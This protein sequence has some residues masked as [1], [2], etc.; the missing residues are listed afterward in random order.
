MSWTWHVSPYHLSTCSTAARLPPS[1]TPTRLDISPPSPPPSASLSLPWVP[2]PSCTHLP[3]S[4][5]AYVQCICCPLSLSSSPSLHL[6]GG[7]PRTSAVEPRALL[8]RNRHNSCRLRSHAPASH[9]AA[10]P[11]SLSEKSASDGFRPAR[12]SP[13]LGRKHV[14]VGKGLLQARRRGRKA[15][16]PARRPT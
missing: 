5:G 11:R 14:S 9:A 13:G 1:S 15:K 10:G 6:P 8:A 3:I 16:E 7:L 2:R 12:S 4:P